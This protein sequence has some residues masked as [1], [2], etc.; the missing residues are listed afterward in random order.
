M[1]TAIL[2]SGQARTFEHCVANQRHL[3]YERIADPHFFVSVAK[4]ED[5]HAANL[6]LKQYRPERVHIEVV[7]Q[8]EVAVPDNVA[9][10]LSV[11][12]HAIAPTSTVQGVLKQYWHLVRVAEFAGGVAALKSYDRVI[13]LRPDIKFTSVPDEWPV[14]KPYEVI[15]PWWARAGGVNDRFAIMGGDAAGF[16]FYTLVWAKLGGWARGN[17]IHPESMLGACLHDQGVEV[18]PT[19][20]TTFVALRRSGELILPD[21]SIADVADILLRLERQGRRMIAIPVPTP[22]SGKMTAN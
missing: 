12:A 18:S 20:A 7:E 5:A 10:L 9:D 13:R 17:P 6:L 4:D 8:P 2:I 15:A 14:P 11:S 1:R 21:T 22:P 19:L 16:Y 3:L